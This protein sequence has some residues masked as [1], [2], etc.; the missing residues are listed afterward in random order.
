MRGSGSWK[1]AIL[2]G[3]VFSAIYAMVH[4]EQWVVKGQEPG[5]PTTYSSGTMGYK[6]LYLWLKDLGIPV[7]RWEKDLK[8]LPSQAKVLVLFEP[9]FGPEPGE[10]K[11][12]EGWVRRGGTLFIATQREGFFLEPFGLGPG[13]SK[14][15]SSKE[16]Q[17]IQPGP[18]VRGK[19]DI[20]SER[21]PDISPRPADLV[22]HIR[23]PWGAL[24][25][26]LERGKGRVMVLTDPGLFSN[27]RLKQGDNGRLALEFLLNHLG[28]GTL[29]VDEYH[30]GYGR[31]TSV[32][33]HFLRSGLAGLLLQSTLIILV[34]WAAAGRRF[35]PP[36][37]LAR[38]TARSPMEFVRAMAGL[39][40]RARANRLALETLIRWTEEEASRLL[41]DKDRALRESLRQSKNR[42]QA[43]EVTDRD[44]LFESKNLHAALEK[45]K[46]HAPGG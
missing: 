14:G 30:H 19:R 17:G 7:E 35:G 45:A 20:R 22:V 18:Y 32:T 37:P 39:F 4:L 15:E 12:L 40:Q 6:V 21:H 2:F 31:V 42:Y 11:A 5:T 25:G 8:S 23:D 16:G 44:L 28:Q 38:Y 36:R 13:E 43:N 27:L 10:L 46:R 34:L 33:G 1:G 26:V 41:V 9:S 24:L 29:L 3:V